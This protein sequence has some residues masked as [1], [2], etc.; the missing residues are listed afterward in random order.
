[1]TLDEI[2]QLLRLVDEH[3]RVTSL[4]VGDVT[5]RCQVG[6]SVVLAPEEEPSLPEGVIDPSKRLR[7]I[8]R[9]YKTEGHV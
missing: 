8:H 7:E 5:V 3:P 9:K 2:A 4:T 6:E 1:M